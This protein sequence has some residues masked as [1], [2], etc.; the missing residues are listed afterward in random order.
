[1]LKFIHSEFYAND[2]VIYVFSLTTLSDADGLTVGIHFMVCLPHMA[3]NNTN[4]DT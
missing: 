1:M 2:K 3:R 4:D